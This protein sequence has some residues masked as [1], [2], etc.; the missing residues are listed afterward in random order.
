MTSLIC[1]GRSMAFSLLVVLGLLYPK[2]EVLAQGRVALVIGNAAYR[3]VGALENPR[4]DADAIAAALE[5]LGFNV[6]KVMDG[7][8][9][10]MRRGVLA[11]SRSVYDSHIAIVFFAGHGM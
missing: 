3:H 8:F 7:N 5:R 1:A 9:D 6:M 2:Y 4:N 11:F 10:A